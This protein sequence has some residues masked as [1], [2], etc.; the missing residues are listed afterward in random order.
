[1]I[2]YDTYITNLDALTVKYD[3][4]IINNDTHIY[5]SWRTDNKQWYKKECSHFN[6]QEFVLFNIL[7]FVTFIG[8]Y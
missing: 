5:K 1:M 3:T 4:L 6:D 7:L 8:G 2:N